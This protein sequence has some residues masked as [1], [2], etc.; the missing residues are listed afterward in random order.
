MNSTTTETSRAH[1]VASDQRVLESRKW[2]FSVGGNIHRAIRSD[3]VIPEQTATSLRV[4]LSKCLRE[5][6]RD[7]W[8]QFKALV[9]GIATEGMPDEDLTQM[10]ERLEYL[11]QKVDERAS[12]TP[13]TIEFNDAGIELGRKLRK[14]R[15][16][17]I[18]D[19]EQL[20]QGISSARQSSIAA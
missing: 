18:Y 6:E 9:V 16:G 17:I 15:C 10:F 13:E 3:S 7:L 5:T 11:T 19:L 12:I 4:L 14:L 20:L 1:E 2:S 8:L